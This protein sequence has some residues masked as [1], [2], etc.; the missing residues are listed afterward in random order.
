MSII[1][2]H[3]LTRTYGRRRG[4]E[5]VELAVPEGSLFGFLGPNGAGKTTVIRVLMGFLRASSGEG[6]VFGLDCWKRGAKIRADVGYV[7]GD[8]RLYPWLDGHAALSIFGGIRG[9]DLRV[10]GRGIAELLGLDLT[11]RVRSMSRGTRQK[12]G[13]VLALAHSPRLLILDE[14]TGGLDPIVQDRLRGH[15]KRL[16]GS[17]HTVFFSSHTLSEVEDLC[18]RVAIV[19]DGR[20]V[21]QETLL[22]LRQHAGH[23]VTIRWKSGDAAGAAPPEFLTIESREDH[24]W[25]ASLKGAVRPLVDWLAGREIEDLHIGPPDLDRLFR[26][27]YE[28]ERSGE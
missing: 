14:P 20:I 9:R 12:L 6:R 27:Y 21:A 22:T 13:L 3:R 28:K 7:P 15:L 5:S 16:A 24:T 4:I 2:A 23:E 11:V 19:R 17:G 18:D 1:E 10:P 26:R 8:L 25:R